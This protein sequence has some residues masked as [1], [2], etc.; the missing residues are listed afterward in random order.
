MHLLGFNVVVFHSLI[1]QQAIKEK[2]NS[3]KALHGSA[4]L[5]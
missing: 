2:N 4:V 3:I 1:S 5:H